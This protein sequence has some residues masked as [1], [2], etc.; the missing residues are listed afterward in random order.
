[1]T[2]VFWT[3]RASSSLRATG[4]GFASGRCALLLA[5]LELLAVGPAR[6]FAVDQPRSARVLDLPLLP[7][8]PRQSVPLRQALSDIGQLPREG[9]VLFGLEERLTDGKEP[10][11]NL[12]IKADTTLGVALSEILAQLPSYEMEVV[13]GHLINLLPKS[14]KED[15]DDILN[16]RVPKFD[17]V[18]KP[19]YGILND[20]RHAIPGV[21]EALR[22][23][24]E[25]GKQILELYQGGY[26]GNL[27]ITLHLKNVTVRDILN[28]ASV[29]TE[30]S[31]EDHKPDAPRGWICVVNPNPAA[32]NSRY[33]WQ[34]FFSLPRYWHYEFKK[35]SDQKAPVTK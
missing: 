23:K 18:S 28:A 17:A 22:P 3:L 29:A 14:A 26:Q 11:V 9:F 2:K 34:S 21:N 8:E 5:V 19:A 32:G 12:D 16:F 25:P 20:P 15:L 1:M 4:H 30:P 27:L 7:M 35:P 10:A 24:P 31:F 6:L 33:S 13:S